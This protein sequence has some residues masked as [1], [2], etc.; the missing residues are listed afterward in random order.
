[1]HWPTSILA[2]CATWTAGYAHTIFSPSLTAVPLQP[3]NVIV[4]VHHHVETIKLI[5]FGAAR[6]SG[7]NKQ[8]LPLEHSYESPAGYQFLPPEAFQQRPLSPAA[9]MW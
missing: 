5:D 6:H 2:L 7:S 3:D 8:A 9:D 4:Q 1:M